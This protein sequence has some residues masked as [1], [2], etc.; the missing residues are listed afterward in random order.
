M[1]TTPRP[2]QSPLCTLLS[3]LCGLWGEALDEVANTLLPNDHSTWSG[4]KS[5]WHY[6]MD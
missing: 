6:C 2:L 5:C 1:Q 3:W 4:G